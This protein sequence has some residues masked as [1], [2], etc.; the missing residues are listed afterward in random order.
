MMNRLKNTH[1]SS[2]SWTHLMMNA[3]TLKR[4]QVARPREFRASSPRQGPG[5]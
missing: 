3:V 1:Y 5:L 4:R 2:L